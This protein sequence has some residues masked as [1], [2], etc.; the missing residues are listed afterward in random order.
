LICVLGTNWTMEILDRIVNQDEE[1]LH[2]VKTIPLP[3][4]LFE[5]TIPKKFQIWD[6]LGL[7]RR[8]FCTHLSA[9]RLDVER[10]TKNNVKLIYVLRNPKDTLVS[11]YNFFKKLPPF[12]QEPL[13]SLLFNGWDNFYKHYMRG[14]FP[15]DGSN[16]GSYMDHILSWLKYRD[17]KNIHFVFYEDLKKDFNKEVNK[18]AR[19]MEISLSEEK[20][21]EIAEK[22]TITAMRKSYEGRTGIQAKHAAAFIHKGGVGGW[23]NYFT[24]AQSEEWDE[25]VEEKLNKTDIKFQFTI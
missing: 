7:Q 13:K 10:L 16:E 18:L 11:M 4:R 15:V 6:S 3:T 23:K 25:I 17:D 12:Q 19:H 2:K 8:V 22:C 24:V 1:E 9:D 20:L 5:M 21:A 14:A